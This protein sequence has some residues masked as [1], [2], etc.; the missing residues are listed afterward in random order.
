[1]DC[2][3]DNP[4]SLTLA[5]M[6]VYKLDKVA[7]L[8]HIAAKQKVSLSYQSRSEEARLADVQ[9]KQKQRQKTLAPDRTA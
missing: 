2:K 3:S 6:K 4:G 5:M 8:K 7:C 1:M 9:R